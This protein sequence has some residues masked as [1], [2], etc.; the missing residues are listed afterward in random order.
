MPLGYWP[1]YLLPL[2]PTPAPARAL[3]VEKYVCSVPR[4]RYALL[5]HRA[6]RVLA[7]SKGEEAE[8]LGGLMGFLQQQRSEEFG[9]VGGGWV[10]VGSSGL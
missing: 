5:G 7:T 8:G 1:A 4:E 3:Q 2:P 9:Q 6:V 10:G